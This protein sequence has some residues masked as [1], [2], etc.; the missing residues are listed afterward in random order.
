MGL[1]DVRRNKAQHRPLDFLFLLV[2]LNVRP[3]STAMRAVFRIHA[4]VGET[5]PFHRT[6]AYKVFRYNFF[7]V[8]GPH[9]AV[10][11]GFRVNHHGR[12]MFALVQAS[13]FV[14]THFSA[15]SGISRELLQPAVQGAGS[16]G[17]T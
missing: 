17:R 12:P 11:Y 4:A 5:Q 2:L 14:D 15:Q 6:S 10:P 13:G 8:F 3:Q 7:G 16:I 9:V 1:G